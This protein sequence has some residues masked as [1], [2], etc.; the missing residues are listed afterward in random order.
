MPEPVMI[1]SGYTYG[2]QTLLGAGVWTR[3]NQFYGLIIQW[4]DNVTRISELEVLF[5]TVGGAINM[6]LIAGRYFFHW[7]PLHP[8]G[9][10]VAASDPVGIAIFPLFLAWLVQ[11]VLLRF[12]GVRLHRRVQPLFL[13]LLVGYVLGSGLSLLMP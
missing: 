4:M 6:M 10:V 11:V 7:W 12:G 3:G 9:F 2:A 13:G 1:Y 5:L 8:I